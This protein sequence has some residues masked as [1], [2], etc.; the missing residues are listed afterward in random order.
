MGPGSGFSVALFFKNREVIGPGCGPVDCS[1]LV[2]PVDG[3]DL[4]DPVGRVRPVD[5]VGRVGRSSLDLGIFGAGFETF[6]A[7]LP[8][9]LEPGR[10]RP[11]SNLSSPT[12][13]VSLFF[14]SLLD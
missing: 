8:F 5:G 6:G 9:E 12:A 10:K 11:Y 3:V 1:D 4:V 14:F 7:G 2:R 13:I